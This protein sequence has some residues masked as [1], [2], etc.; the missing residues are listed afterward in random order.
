MDNVAYL[1]TKLGNGLVVLT[2]RTIR[3]GRREAYVTTVG[4]EGT[5]I[6]PLELHY[7]ES[8]A[9]AMRSHDEVCRR[10]QDWEE[11]R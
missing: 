9:E 7:N 1:Q 5:P 4:R 8:S 3:R 2:R 11:D 10:W 6:L